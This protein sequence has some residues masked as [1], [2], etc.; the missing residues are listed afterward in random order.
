MSNIQRNGKG[1]VA[2]PSSG[3]SNS[4]VHAIRNKI[5]N[6]TAETTTADAANNLAILTNTY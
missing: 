5:S 3:A 4:V 6:Q 1:Y 2:A